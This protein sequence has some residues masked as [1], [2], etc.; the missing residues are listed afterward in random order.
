MN[1]EVLADGIQH[2]IFVIIRTIACLGFHDL[3]YSTLEFERFLDIRSADRHPLTSHEKLQFS[4]NL[5]GLI[6]FL[7]ETQR[8]QTDLIRIRVEFNGRSQTLIC[9]S[10][11]ADGES[12]LCHWFS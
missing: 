3:K 11:I 2:G 5:C 9:Y 6:H 8:N 4:L 1:I 10:D 7:L 12:Y